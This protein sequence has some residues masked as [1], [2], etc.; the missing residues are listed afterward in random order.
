M[1]LIRI[2]RFRRS[3]LA[4]GSFIWGLMFFGASTL[5]GENDGAI[6]AEIRK[7][8]SGVVKIVSNSDRGSVSL[9]DFT[10]SV[11]S[12]GRVDVYREGVLLQNIGQFSSADYL[13][14]LRSLSSIFGDVGDHQIPENF[15]KTIKMYSGE[16]SLDFIKSLLGTPRVEADGRAEFLAGGYIFTMEYT[17][18]L[19]EGLPPDTVIA[20]KI[21]IDPD[22]SAIARDPILF[23]GEWNAED[24]TEI[25]ELDV[26]QNAVLGVSTVREFGDTIS[27]VGWEGGPDY[28][29]DYNFLC[30]HGS[31]H[32][33]GFIDRFYSVGDNE[34]LAELARASELSAEPFDTRIQDEMVEICYDL[35]VIA[36]EFR[37]GNA[38]IK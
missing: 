28:N 19:S 8:C 10:L 6:V 15:L 27:S 30:V 18:D 16:T 3:A 33:E 13:S 25:C 2:S 35:P 24:C 17:V 11:T 22:S 37:S 38:P 14:C 31:V 4:L 36:V 9:Q 34:R 32:T 26:S 29:Q 21:G 20:Y 5:G 1:H 23:D 12:T 7:A